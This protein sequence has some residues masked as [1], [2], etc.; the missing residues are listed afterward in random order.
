MSGFVHLHCHTEFSLLDGAI[1]ISD[2]VKKAQALGM[3]ATAITDHGNLFGTSYF[4]AACKD[5]GISPILGCEV[6]VTKDH[7]D[8]ESELAKVRHHLI[9]LAQNSTGYANLMELVSQ[10]FIKGFYYKPRIDKKMLSGH[11][12]GLIALSAC[13]AGEIPRTLRGGNKLIPGGGNF[14]DARQIAH[15]YAKLFPGR[16][17]LEVQANNL[18]DQ[19]MVNQKLLE[20]AD[21][22]KLPL[23]ATNDC[24]Y[25]NEDDWE[26]HDVLLCIGS[27]SQ[28]NDA[29]RFK[30]D[31]TDLYYKSEEEMLAGLEGIPKEAISN[32]LTI[33]DQCSG[34][35]IQLH[36]PP[37]H[38]PIYEVPEGMTLATTFCKMAR[39]GLKKRLASKKVDE[40]EYYD[41]LELELK[42]ICDMGFPGYFLIVQDYIN[43][44]KSNDIPVGPG[45]GSAAGS[46]VAWSLGITTIDPLPNHLFFERFLNS[47]RVSMPDI[48]VDFCE[49]RRLE[50]LDY[51]TLKYGKDRVA[52]IAAFGTLK[53]KGVI[54]DVGRALGIPFN[55]TT[56]IA[57]L[58]PNDLKMTLQKALDTVPELAQ[59][60]KTKPETRKLFDISKRLE[61]LARHASTH[62]AGVVVSDRPMHEYVSLFTGKKGEQVA[63]F[64][65]KFIEKVGLVKFDFLGLRTMTVI[66]NAV[67]NII[68][69]GKPAPDMENLSTD[70]QNVYDMLSR[71]DTDGIFQLESSGMRK[72]LRMLKPSG[73]EDLVAMLALYRPGPLNSG[74]VDEFIKRKHGEIEVTYPLPELEN[75]LKD[76]YGVIVYQEQVMQIAQ[77]TAKYTLG[78]A[79]LLR[80]AMGKKKA[81]E[82]AKQRSIFLAGASERGVSEQ[83]ANEIFDLMEKFAE[84]GF[85]KAHSA[86][87]AYITY[88]TA[89]LK[90]YYKVEYMA[91]L[92]SS[93]ASNQDKILSYIAACRDMEVPV[94]PPDVQKSLRVFVPNANAIIYGL[95]GVKNVGDEAINEIVQSRQKNGPYKS[96]YDMC[97]RVNL[98]KVTKRVL[99][100]LIKSGACDCFGVSRAGLLASIDEV[101]SKAQKKQKEANTAQTSLLLF[102][103]KTKAV[104]MPGIGFPCDAQDLPEW[105]DDQKLAFEKDS[106]GFYLTS[107]PLQPY[108]REMQRLGLTTLEEVADLQK[109]QVKIGILVTGLKEFITRKGDKMAFLQVEDLTGHAEVTVFPK[110]YTTVAEYLQRERPLLEIT[111][112]LDSKDADLQDNDEDTDNQL[113]DI[114]LLCDAARP[115][116]DACRESD[117]P[118]LITYPIHKTS[119]EDFQEFK[120]ILNKHQGSSTLQIQFELMHKNCIMEL[121]PKWKVQSSPQFH[122]DIESW[123]ASK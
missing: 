95:G 52:Q 4:Y 20:L 36:A 107:H 54:K 113:M 121:G 94:L 17:Y 2:L 19:A 64:D 115:L 21:D 76:T 13:I 57:K 102:A 24:H 123:A 85:N 67:R 26:A 16:F 39:E 60:Y 25:L 45:R 87:Y 58:I 72:Y 79:D 71:G 110:V 51:V 66:D 63:S 37:Y 70:D 116:E 99:E 50:V 117:H 6:Y 44:A 68:A 27:Q 28:V 109:G 74:M 15:D 104:S 43:W 84:Y 114:K 7:T 92:L 78:G 41:R 56:R 14:N 40:K 65:M 89:F 18:P 105:E 30:F 90:N 53:A 9:L 5:H 49:D 29:R 101:V 12:D 10:S 106:L 59:E 112:T 55:E 108:R 93:E 82:M 46:V 23:V 69:Q 47:E 119:D 100:S 80:R 33:A 42:V 3:P 22:V 35:E 120:A 91:A 31:A 38:F 32:T 81:E 11:T 118:V 83:K 77:I 61:G 111:G 8:K 96:F 62:A 75:C 34:L 73:F 48:D 97:C 103:P 1:K 88:E 122:K 86:A 98:R